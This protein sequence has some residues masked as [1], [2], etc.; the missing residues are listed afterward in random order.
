MPNNIKFI[1]EDEAQS[2]SDELNRPSRMSFREGGVTTPDQQDIQGVGTVVAQ[3]P[4][5][6]FSVVADEY[7]FGGGG[8]APK[9]P[10]D[11]TTTKGMAKL[12]GLKTPKELKKELPKTPEGFKGNF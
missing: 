7:K 9:P 12:L 8:T 5:E 6:T 2:Y 1:K 4:D 10:R 11:I 3:N